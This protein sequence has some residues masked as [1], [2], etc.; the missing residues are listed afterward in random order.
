MWQHTLHERLVSSPSSFWV[1]K[2]CPSLED[3]SEPTV[4]YI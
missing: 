1:L 2:T 4:R 3:L